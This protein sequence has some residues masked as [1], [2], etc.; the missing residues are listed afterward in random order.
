[1]TLSPVRL[2]PPLPPIRWEKLPED[3]PLPD[4]PVE[5]T[6]QPL[7]AAALREALELAQM[8]PAQAL[9]ASNFGL[10]S[11]VG[12]KV[13]VKAPD[14]VYVPAVQPIPEGEIR[15]SYTPHLEGDPP[16]IVME[17]I[18]ETEG[19]E[20]SINPHYPYGKWYFYERILQVP[21]YVIFHPKTGELD[22]YRLENGRYTPVSADE[23]RRYWIPEIGL[24]LGVWRGQKAET[25]ANWLRWWT[26]DGNLLLWGSE[27]I[28]QERQRA[29]QERQRA[30]QE[31]Q[32]AEQ[33][34]Q[35][36]EAAE[37]ALEQARLEQQ[38]LAAKL[39]ELG[40]DPEAIAD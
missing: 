21:V 14:W 12:D 35:R 36:A 20:Y 13:V 25:K 26:A 1:M 18:S 2:T 39:R 6:L 31:R 8:I 7:L 23:N 17:F 5:S 4:E 37:A 40:V 10:C 9:I 28:E 15:R 24:F 3:F 16:A 32:R 29:E 19:G 22:V 27:H 34:R 38:R 11:T 30:E 33:E